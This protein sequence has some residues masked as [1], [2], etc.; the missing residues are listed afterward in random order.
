MENQAT[1]DL[2]SWTLGSLIPQWMM[3]KWIRFETFC[4]SLHFAPFWNIEILLFT[5]SLS[6]IISAQVD[7]SIELTCRAFGGTLAP[8]N[9]CHSQMCILVPPRKKNSRISIDLLRRLVAMATDWKMYDKYKRWAPVLFPKFAYN[10]FV[11]FK[12]DPLQ[13]CA[14]YPQLPQRP[15]GNFARFCLPDA[16]EAFW[17][18][19]FIELFDHFLRNRKVPKKQQISSKSVSLKDLEIGFHDFWVH[20]PLLFPPAKPETHF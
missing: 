4:S 11:P 8:P 12:K 16:E 5:S 15:W 10:D 13:S 19:W 2:T 9:C 14:L 1:S 17:K 3:E 18:I 20:F 7:F 6:F